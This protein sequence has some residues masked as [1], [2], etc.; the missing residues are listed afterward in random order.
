MNCIACGLELSGFAK[1]CSAC[2]AAQPA[3]PAPEAEPEPAASAEPAAL[4]LAP[5]PRPEPHPEPEPELTPELAPEPQ[6]P[7]KPRANR[8]VGV[9]IL[10]LALLVAAG[11]WFLNRGSHDASDAEPGAAGHAPAAKAD[12]GPAHQAAASDATS[13]TRQDADPANSGSQRKIAEMLKK[14][15]EESMAD[16]EN[17]YQAKQAAKKLNPTPRFVEIPPDDGNIKV[18]FTVNLSDPG[19]RHYFQTKIVLRTLD[20]ASEKAIVS[21]RPVLNSKII[22]VL[23]GRTLAETSS[24][25]GKVAIAN[26]VALVANAVLDPLLTLIYILQSEPTDETIASLVRI[27]AIPKRLDDGTKCCSAAMKEAA[28]RFWPLTPSDLP[29]DSALFKSFVLQ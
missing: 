14:Y 26:D 20:A 19:E 11:F 2:G 18:E 25:A 23:T 16:A 10:A 6:A 22:I 24:A 12:H 9:A 8:S 13:S 4:P 17:R 21:M 29:V 1:F 3:A 7:T 28:R 15:T 27:G 5:E